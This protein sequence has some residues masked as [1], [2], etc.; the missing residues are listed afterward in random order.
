MNNM[1][2]NLAE[3][4]GDGHRLFFYESDAEIEGIGC[5]FARIENIKRQFINI[6]N[7]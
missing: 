4:T 3:K 1:Q 7:Q 6:D 2:N 5:R